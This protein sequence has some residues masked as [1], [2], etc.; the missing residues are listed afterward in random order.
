MIFYLGHKVEEEIVDHKTR[1]ARNKAKS[2]KY[3]YD[4]SIDVIIISKDGTLGEIYY[5][6]GLQIGLP[7]KPDHKEILNWDKTAANQKWKR[8]AVPAGLNE[9]TQFDPKY[10][11]FIETQ[12]K[13]REEGVWI[14]LNGKAVY[15]TGTY[16]FFLP[17]IKKKMVIQNLGLFKM[18]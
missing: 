9:E 2:W 15:L 10:V 17:G 11:D 16:W 4:E 12:F 3:G 18:N 6:N 8:E 14:Y 1:L 13:R 7:E 5:V